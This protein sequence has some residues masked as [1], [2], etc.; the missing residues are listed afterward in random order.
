MHGAARRTRCGAEAKTSPSM[1]PARE[2][3]SQQRYVDRMRIA[4]RRLSMGAELVRGGV[5]FRVF[6]PK[7][8]R[9]EIVLERRDGAPRTVTLSRGNE[10]FFAGLADGV[11]AGARYRIRLDDDATLYPDPASRFQPEGPHEASEVIDPTTFAWTDQA[12]TGLTLEGQVIYEMHV[13]TFTTEGTYAAA[14]RELAELRAAGITCIELMPVGEFPGRFG[15]GYDG[16]DLY[17]PT[18]LYGRPDELRAFVDHA[19]ALGLGV[20]LDVVYNH[21]GPS[22]NYLTQ[23]SDHYF[24]AKYENEWGAAV[25][26][27]TEPGARAYFVENA[28]YW[29]DEFHFDGLRLDA[30]QSIHDASPRHV[31]VD[32]GERARAAAGKRKIVLV[33]ENEPQHT[34][35]VRPV[36]AGGYGLDALWNDDFHHSAHVAVTG[37]SEAYYS[38]TKGTP[39]ELVSA[40]KWGYLF[41]GQYYPWQKQCRGMPALDI[42]APKFV[43]YVQ[44]HDQIANSARGQRLQELTSA[45]RYRAITAL[46]LLAPA[47]PM[48]F[49]GQEFAASAPFLYFADHEPELAE[50][51][52]KGRGDFV[53]QFPSLQDEQTSAIRPAPHDV[54][55]FESCKLDFGE[56][57]RHRASYDLTKDL[58]RLRREDPTFAA[59]RSDWLHGAVLGPEAFVLRYAAGT[60]GDRLV[61]VNLGA[62]LDLAEVAEPLLAPLL[63]CRWRVVLSTEDP[64]Y[65]GNGTAPIPS[66]CR[67]RLMGHSALVLA[68]EEDVE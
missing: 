67:I 65:G 58:L 20:I 64:R 66:G 18:R 16:V 27:E 8:K 17:A 52:E 55:T 51:V 59:Q 24:T 42:E 48:L 35:L 26:F 9:V 39:Q 53:R 23:F 3:P 45:G 60:G 4:S 19:H 25:D 37:R 1:R 61:L 7:R 32:I 21:L 31:I 34:K 40:I 33:S 62:D 14:M 6:A 12:W 57:E 15:W 30:T 29:I 2:L 5:E 46:T 56:R 44:N 13:G 49:Q 47:T 28:G 41:Q 36:D 10:G 50:L 22:G 68:P 43:L 63:G 54:K 38:S 11:T